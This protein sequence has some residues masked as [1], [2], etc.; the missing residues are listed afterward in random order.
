MQREHPIPYDL[1]HTSDLPIASF[2]EDDAEPRGIESFNATGF[3]LSLEN[4]DSLSHA[5]DERLIEWTIDRHLVFPLMPVLSSENLI[6][7][8]PVIGKQDKPGR[9]FIKSADWKDPLRM[10]DLRNDVMRHMR[11]TSRRHTHRFVILDIEWGRSPGNHLP[12]SCDD[13]V[14]T[15]LIPQASYSLVDGDATGL[16]QT[17][18]LS[19]R[20]DAVVCKKL[21]DAKRIGHSVGMPFQWTRRPALI[22]PSMR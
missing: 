19:P 1:A 12:I 3:G 6:H 11:F 2:S 7:D 9:V 18:S 10:A 21:I 13:V 20:T 14:R 16:D 4:D 8:I 5:L 22:R 15:D 17:I